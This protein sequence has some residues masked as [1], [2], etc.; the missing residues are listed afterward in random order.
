MRVFLDGV[1]SNK[2]DADDRY[3]DGFSIQNDSGFE[4]PKAKR[5]TRREMEIDRELK[6]VE[7]AM[8][9]I[10]ITLNT[11]TIMEQLKADLRGLTELKLKLLKERG[12]WIKPNEGRIVE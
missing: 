9:K 4:P 1:I 12:L 10:K 8:N 11:R 6:A 2:Q 3:R 5:R 7:M